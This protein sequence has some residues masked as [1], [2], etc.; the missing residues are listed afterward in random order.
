VADRARL[1]DL[2]KMAQLPLG[3]DSFLAG[4]VGGHARVPANW[5]FGGH[6]KRAV[7]ILKSNFQALGAFI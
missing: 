3:L 5:L 2:V 4:L 7:K 1:D 6:L